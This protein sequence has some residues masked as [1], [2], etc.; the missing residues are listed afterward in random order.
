MFHAA[1]ASGKSY[2]WVWKTDAKIKLLGHALRAYHNA[3]VV[4]K[5]IDATQYYLAELSELERHYVPTVEKVIMYWATMQ[6]G[7]IAFS[8]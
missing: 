4:N 5:E 3:G 1:Y 8:A 2:G 7:E 6:S